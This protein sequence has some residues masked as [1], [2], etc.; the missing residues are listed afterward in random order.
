MQRDEVVRR[1]V[2]SG[3]YDANRS[4]PLA[5]APLRVGVVTSTSGA[6]WA[7]FVHELERSGL[8]FQVRVIDVRV[9]GDQAV[10]M[11]TRAIRTLGRHRDLDVVAV[12]RGGGATHRAGH[13]RSRGHRHGDRHLPAAGAHRARPRD[14]P[15]RRR[16]GRPRQPEDAHG[17]RRG[18]RR[19]G[20][21]VPRTKRAGVGGGVSHRRPSAVAL[22][23]PT[24]RRRPRHAPSGGRRDRAIG[25]TSPPARLAARQLRRRPAGPRRSP[26]GRGDR[27]RRSVAGTGRR[28][29]RAI[30][31]RSP[32]GCACSTRCTR[33]PE[34][35][36]SPAPPTAGS[37]APPRSWRPATRS[38]RTFAAGAPRSV[39][40]DVVL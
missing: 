27:R 10:D 31:T 19:A 8:G 35:G 26:A 17:M 25:R 15:Q 24:Q 16:R 40:Q 6:A 2:A 34:G 4:R 37:S 9:Q 28:S 18:A 30:S 39:V 1:L 14:R 5:V 36:A 23:R 21:R 3:L 7:D 11:V 13:V 33:W 12:V 38:S 32:P 20:R 22:G 29:R